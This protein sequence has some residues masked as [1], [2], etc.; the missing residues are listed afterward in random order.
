MHLY[1][2]S[3]GKDHWYILSAEDTCAYVGLT[4][5]SEERAASIFRAEE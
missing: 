3:S 2:V 1:L 5:V 4:D